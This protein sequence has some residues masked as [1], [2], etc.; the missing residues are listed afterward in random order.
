M[1]NVTINIKNCGCGGGKSSGGGSSGGGATG[2]YNELG[3]PN[4]GPPEG[5]AFPTSGLSDRQCKMAVWI[6]DWIEAGLTWFGTTTSGGA[7][8][9]LVRYFTADAIPSGLRGPL[10]IAI[11]AAVGGII[12]LLVTG[13]NPVGA[14]VLGV[15]SIAITEAII[16]AWTFVDTKFFYQ[17][18]IANIIP[19]IQ[20]LKSDLI[21]ALAQANSGEDA[22][23]KLTD[24]IDDVDGLSPDE[25][26]F[27]LGLIPDS[28]LTMLYFE[29]DWWPSF[30]DD[31][32]AGITTACC[33]GAVNDTPITPGSAESC[34]ASY[35]I[36]QQLVATM[37]AVA[38]TSG[39]WYN[40]NPFD[41]DRPEIYEWLD[42]NLATPRKIKERAFSYSSFLNSITEITYSKFFLNVHLADLTEFSDFADYI[43]GDVAT[44]TAA[45]QAA[46]DTTEAYNALQ[47][48][49]DWI[50]TNIEPGDSVV[51]DY[52]QQALDALITP[53]TDKPGILDL[54]FFQDA[55][56]A[57]YALIECA[58]GGGGS[59][60]LTAILEVNIT[61]T[62]SDI[63]DENQI[64][65]AEDS[66][67]DTGGMRVSSRA[68]GTFGDVV[69]DFGQVH[70]GAIGLELLIRGYSQY[71]SYRFI[72][73][74]SFQVKEN[75]GDEWTSV[76]LIYMNQ[77]H[78]ADG[79]WKW[80]S[81]SFAARNVRYCRLVFNRGQSLGV[82]G[83]RWF[84][85]LKV[86]TE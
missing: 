59:G 86:V 60:Y 8:L 80:R 66:A 53:P 85:A 75:L 39:I 47:P 17:D 76:G 1:G 41:N 10:R 15:L 78:W 67:D 33:G 42:S 2:G 82:T 51:A 77:S 48:L 44:L 73:T 5:Y 52:M 37:Q 38:D 21:C 27:L 9:N 45:L 34:Q 54:L 72:E 4:Q 24:F 46:A 58:G 25:E 31:Y 19:K 55:D 11:E 6:Y 28:F 22:K 74:V 20:V 12:G 3:D 29:P 49:R 23:Q 71:E 69:G 14:G 57:N 35:Y 64:L 79:V 83:Y 70:N 61:K 30:D 40:W 43:N 18:K 50:T 56:L 26:L 16:S 81:V 62:P 84:D 65:G 7:T 32:L 63:I 36:I 68:D 13:G